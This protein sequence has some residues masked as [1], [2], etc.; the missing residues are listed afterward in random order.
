MNS[1]SLPEDWR[2]QLAG[3]VLNDL[4]PEKAVLVEHW[5]GQYP[6]VAAELE[7]LQT[8]WESLP[9]GLEPVV[10]PPGVRDRI[11]T[12]VQPM[13]SAPAPPPGRD[14]SRRRFPWVR[15]GLGLGRHRP[16]PG[17]HSAR[18]PA[19]APGPASKR[20]RGGQL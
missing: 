9:N 16:G 3:Y 5:L 7:T 1:T 12:A 19:P 18:K 10:P 8:T 6:E 4:T 20:G 2:S 13:I 11:L 14:P 17:H 15:L